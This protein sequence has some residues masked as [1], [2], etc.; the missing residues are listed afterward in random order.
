MASLDQGGFTVSNSGMLVC[1]G[2]SG[3]QV[4]SSEGEKKAERLWKVRVTVRFVL[5]HRF[6]RPLGGILAAE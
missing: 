5:G 3:G 2:G 6:N 4:G 1:A